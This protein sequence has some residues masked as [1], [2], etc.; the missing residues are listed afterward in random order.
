MNKIHLTE[1]T[2]CAVASLHARFFVVCREA[3]NEGFSS[4]CL[5]C[6]DLY[7][8]CSFSP[9]CLDH[10]STDRRSAPFSR[11]LCRITVRLPDFSRRLGDARHQRHYPPKPLDNLLQAVR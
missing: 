5:V 2:V 9:V 7:S 1:G 4:P 11:H 6:H 3:T 10:A 8:N